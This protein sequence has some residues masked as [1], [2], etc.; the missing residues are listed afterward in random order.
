MS[1]PRKVP[2]Y[3]IVSSAVPFVGQKWKGY[4]GSQGCVPLNTQKSVSMDRLAPGEPAPPKPTPEQ[5]KA[6]AAEEAHQ[7]W[8]TQQAKKQP[9]P[10]GK[11]PGKP[12]APDAEECENPPVFDMLD[13][14]DAMEKMKL[15]VAA[16]LARKWFYGSKA[17][18][19]Q[20]SR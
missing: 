4:T 20:F 7:K 16:K 1:S 17:I 13:I 3:M 19:S 15:P 5:L 10:K 9:R 18:L 8:R 12:A 2:Y 11:P 14:P 6:K